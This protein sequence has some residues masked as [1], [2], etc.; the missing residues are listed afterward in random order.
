MFRRPNMDPERAFMEA[1]LSLRSKKLTRQKTWNSLRET[2]RANN[3]PIN[4]RTTKDII[5]RELV[6]KQSDILQGKYRRNRVKKDTFF[7]LREWPGAVARMELH[8]NGAYVKE[9]R[10]TWNVNHISTRLIM[11]KITPHIEMRVKVVYSFSAEIY[12]ANDISDYG[13]LI[14]A[15]GHLFTSIAEVR[16]YIE[17]YEQRRLDL[18]DDEVW[19]KAYLP[20]DRETGDVGSY[21]G[22]VVFKHVQV[23]LLAS[24][25]PLI[26]CGPLPDWLGK[27]RCIYTVDKFDDN[28]C[29]WRCLAI[30]KNIQSGKPRADL[31]VCMMALKLAREYYKEPKLKR[32]DVRETKLVDMEEIAKKFKVNIMVYEPKGKSK[33]I[34]KLA[35]G[36]RQYKAKLPTMNVGL[37]EGHCFYI[38]DMKVLC[39]KWECSGCGQVFTDNR[40]LTKY[41]REGRCNCGKI[42]I[43]F[44]GDKIKPKMSMSDKVF[45]R[46]NTHF[47]YA[48]CQWIEAQSKET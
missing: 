35:Y 26:G 9:F 27:K 47:S 43:I 5:E 18:D 25:E 34:C 4:R 45:Y 1:E 8:S 41:L 12:G 44:N 15:N 48:G 32:T 21:E 24:N 28:L 19:S 30:H 31:Y 42:K 37:F 20:A 14:P 40:N 13:K 7:T 2:A 38:K 33:H 39:Q 46:G 11:D 6:K 22:K 17:Q 23:K 3:I 29:L 36:Q 10:V 16:D